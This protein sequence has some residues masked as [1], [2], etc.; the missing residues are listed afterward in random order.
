MR[1]STRRPTPVTAPIDDATVLADVK[2]KL[3]ADR[4]LRTVDVIVKDGV[5]E[6]RGTVPSAAARQRAVDLVR[7]TNGVAQVIDRLTLKQ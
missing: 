6:L 2:S 3:A 5:L 4:Q 7:Q 1:P